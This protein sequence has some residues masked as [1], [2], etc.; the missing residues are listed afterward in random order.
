MKKKHIIFIGII[1][2]IILAGIIASV[3]KDNDKL[4]FNKSDPI[5]LYTI[6]AKEK[7]FVNG[8]IVPEKVENIYQDETKGN[9]NNVSVTDGQVVTKGDALF[10][11][12]SD[13]I[14]NQ[15]DEAK[16]QIDSSNEQK[17]RLVIKKRDA[18]KLLAK[19]Q[20]EAKE[21][22]VSVGATSASKGA[23][24][25]ASTEAQISGY[26]DQ[27]D[28]VQTQIDTTD[29]KV[30]NLEDKEFT[31]VSAPIGGK[32]LLSDSKDKTKPYIVIEATTFYVKGSINEKDQ[33]KLAE[34]QQVDIL[35]FAI[36]KTVTGKVKSVGNSPVAA[37]ASVA[38]QSATSTASTVSYYDANISLDSQENIIN[39][40]HVQATIKLKEEDMKIPK[41]SILEEN[42]KQY[43]FKVVSK[44][45]T[46]KQ[47][48]YEKSNSS[49]VIVL[50]GLSEND[51]I[52]KTS[53]D[54][55]EGIS[56]E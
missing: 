7:V 25:A 43:V 5:S 49:Q 50:S 45:L 54:M 29:A 48:T 23:S 16:Q 19:Q 53:K 11:Y 1:F 18:K 39:G 32:V 34:N 27:I 3:L 37:E 14:S 9:V 20:K 13:E 38:A 40:F 10:T 8:I 21:Q 42:G 15:I 55:K 17:E 6:P 30:K 46:K 35:I 52:A 56:V 24:N 47:I 2:V 36:N 51:S 33:T 4:A 12:K 28:V 41:S 44:K 26:E 31:Y 22:V